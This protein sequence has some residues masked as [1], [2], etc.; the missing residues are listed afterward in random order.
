MTPND[1]GQFGESLAERHLIKQEYRVLAKNFRFKKWEVD[2]IAEKNN[3]VVVV[4]V[5]TR[6]TA[7]IGEPYKAVTRSKQ[8]QIILAANHYIQSNQIWV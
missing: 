5:K 7:E 8:K 1:L 4:E 2:I 3:L 6:N